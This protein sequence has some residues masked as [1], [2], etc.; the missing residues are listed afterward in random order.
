MSSFES[1]APLAEQPKEP[2]ES[3]TR[4]ERFRIARAQEVRL[5]DDPTPTESEV[6]FRETGSWPEGSE[7][8]RELTPAEQAQL[9]EIRSLHP[10]GDPLADYNRLSE[11]IF[12]ALKNRRNPSLYPRTDQQALISL[13][14]KSRDLANRG[15]GGPERA[16]MHRLLVLSKGPWEL[17]STDEDLYQSLVDAQQ[18]AVARL[19]QHYGIEGNTIDEVN[20]QIELWQKRKELIEA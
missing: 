11:A 12:P 14:N 10:T 4:N 2:A 20:E 1:P 16:Y 5:I 13:W 9:D 7:L 17:H 18:L 15:T 3:D 6:Y 8:T 19:L